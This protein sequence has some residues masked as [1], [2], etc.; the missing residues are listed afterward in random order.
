MGIL[1]I[2]VSHEQKVIKYLKS[3]GGV[4]LTLVGRIVSS[5]RAGQDGGLA[6]LIFIKS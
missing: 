2:F 1:E 4:V 6:N 3:K 5:W